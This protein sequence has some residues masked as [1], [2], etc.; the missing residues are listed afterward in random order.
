LMPP[1]ARSA[2]CQP[3]HSEW[4]REWDEDPTGQ[5]SDW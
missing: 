1:K 4:Q 5:D 2:V 3:C